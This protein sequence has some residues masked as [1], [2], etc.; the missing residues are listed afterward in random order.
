MKKVLLVCTESDNVINFRKD[1]ILY[2]IKNNFEVSL[3]CADRIREKEIKDLGIKNY[4]VFSF[5]N[6][7]INP[8]QFFRFSRFI[9]SVVDEFCP[10]TIISFAAK[11]NIATSNA[12]KNKSYNYTDFYC[13]VEG[14]GTAFSKKTL[15]EKFVSKIVSNQYKKCFKKC[16]KV[17]VLNDND[18]DFFISNKM[19]EPQKIIK[20]N[21]IGINV[22]EY[23]PTKDLPKE[24]NV[25][26]LSRLVKEKGI[27]EYCEIAKLVRQTRPDI[28]FLLYGQES[29]LKKEDI[30]QYTNAGIIEYR[31]YTREAAKAISSSRIFALPSYY[32]EGLP[33]TI[34]E[35]CALERPSIAYI[36]TGVTDAIE[37]EKTGFL[38]EKFN[39]KAFANKILSIIDNDVDIKKLGHN[40]R[41]FCKETMDSDVINAVVLKTIEE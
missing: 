37:D 38:I 3:I 26:M 34:M 17:F 35:A 24:K 20:L 18:K 27:I 41:I 22:D 11:P 23:H 16:K 13:F 9:R 14:L 31:G 6:R 7:S 29:T 8:F 39:R 15:K 21:G 10:N 4:N 28:K 19:M 25:L 5:T 1:L 40:A 33:K 30:S 2:L 32:G 36:N 12:I